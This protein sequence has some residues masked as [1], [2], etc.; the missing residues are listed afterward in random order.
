MKNK[1]VIYEKYDHI[2]YKISVDEEDAFMDAMDNSKIKHIIRHESLE[3]LQAEEYAERI[4]EVNF[5][6]AM[7]NFDYKNMTKISDLA[8]TIL[9]ELEDAEDY[10][11]FM[12]EVCER[13]KL[14][15]KKNHAITD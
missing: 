6:D 12:Q 4:L 13:S 14:N 3:E 1:D 2:Y 11:D 9:I 15:W 10:K 8:G 5:I 7:K